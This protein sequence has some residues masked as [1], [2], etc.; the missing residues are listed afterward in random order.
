[1][2]GVFKFATNPVVAF[3]EPRTSLA[4]PLDPC[5]MPYPVT[6]PESVKL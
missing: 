3:Q 4:V 2:I 5:C 6:W 1:M